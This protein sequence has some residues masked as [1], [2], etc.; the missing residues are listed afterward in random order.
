MK[1]RLSRVGARITGDVALR[2]CGRILL[3]GTCVALLSMFFAAGGS[4]WLTTSPLA[5]VKPKTND[6]V[7]VTQDQLHQLEIVKVELCSFRLLKPAIG[8]IAFNEDASTVVLTPFSGSNYQAHSQDRRR[9]ETRGSPV[10]NRQPRGR[11][12]TNRPDC[13]GAG[14]G[15]EQSAT[16]AGQARG[17][18]ANGL[19]CREGY[20]ATGAGAGSSR[21][22]FGRNRP[23]DR[24]RHAS[25]RAQ[26]VACLGWAHRR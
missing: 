24:R 22:R 16:R 19:V 14:G 2:D 15:K 11:P 9:R 23:A 6:T 5:Q 21:L 25:C 10:R 18:S 4:A 3:R 1:Q 7:R 13:R 20:L 12:D 17:R 26:Q 8:Q